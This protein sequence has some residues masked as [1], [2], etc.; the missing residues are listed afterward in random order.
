MEGTAGTYT[1]IIYPHK[2]SAYLVAKIPLIVW[3]KSAAANWIQKN[4]LGFAVDSLDQVAPILEKMTEETY[5]DYQHNLI[6]MS[7]LIREG[8]FEKNAALRAYMA[9]NEVNYT[10]KY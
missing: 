9:V 10:T 6:G 8:I 5:H 2:I 4:G 3:S 7:N 1:K